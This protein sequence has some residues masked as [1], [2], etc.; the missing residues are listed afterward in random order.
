MN[1]I[2]STKAKHIHNCDNLTDL[3]SFIDFVIH[4]FRVEGKAQIMFD[5]DKL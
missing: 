5:V 1:M 2:L 4:E 3:I